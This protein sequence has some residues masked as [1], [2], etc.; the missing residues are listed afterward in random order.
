MSVIAFFFV[1]LFQA[2]T[3]F[4]FARVILSWLPMFGVNINPYSPFVRFIH[5]VT[6]PILEPLRRIIPPIG[7]TLDL[8]AMVAL[9][10]LQFVFIP[11]VASLV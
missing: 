11:V 7:G 10:V 9:I 5:Q 2:L 6:E 3:L 1:L 4:I 8:S